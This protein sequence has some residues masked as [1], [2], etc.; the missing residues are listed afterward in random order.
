MF[1]T[2]IDILTNQTKY[3]IED[4][5]GNIRDLN[6][7][8][9][10][11]VTKNVLNDIDGKLFILNKN[12]EI[13]DNTFFKILIKTNNTGISDSNTILLPIQGTKMFI[14]WGDNSYGVYTQT[15]TPNNIINGFNISHTYETPGEYEIKISSRIT[16]ILFNNGGDRSKL[17]EI[18]QWGGAFWSTTLSAFWGC[19]KMKMPALDAPRNLIN[20]S[21][22]FNGCINFGR[23]EDFTNLNN[24]DVSNV[25]ILNNTFRTA[26]NFNQPL[27]N[28]NTTKVTN[29]D[30]TFR[31]T[32]FNQDISNW[33]VSNV[34]TSRLTFDGLGAFNQDLSNWNITS[35]CTN[36]SEMFRGCQNFNSD[37]SNW[38][39]S[40]VISFFG[41]FQNAR[42]FNQDLS[43]WNVSKCTNFSNMF[44]DARDFNNNGNPDINNWQIN[45]EQPVLMTAMFGTTNA[46]TATVFNQPIGNWNVSSVTNMADM[47]RLNTN[48]NQELNDWDVSNVVN[49]GNMFNGSTGFNKNIG[50]WNVGLGTTFTSFM[51]NKSALN[52]SEENLDNIYNGWVKYKLQPSRSISFGSIKRTTNS[53][54]SK[55]LLTRP[56][57]LLTISNIINNGDDLIRVTTTTP[58]S[59]ITGDMVFIENVIGTIEA[60]GLWSIT[61]VDDFTVDLENSIFVNEFITSGQL[62]T[63][64]GWTIIDGGL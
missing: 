27:S 15:N 13:N 40:N 59:R 18:R 39:V 16:R 1:I 48:F 35:K 49:F 2:A 41:T 31:D 14:D 56:N 64:Y 45:T 33:D 21:N 44:R 20:L 7:L 17:L 52:Y 22:M 34:T 58:H 26:R 47:F 4:K 29:L 9:L 3:L 36:I 55:S 42:I 32:T 63:G 54:N 43:N 23:A 51:A 28:W 24:W 38:D 25:T 19:D 62:R 37:I 6:G 61:Y 30:N 57:V 12:I 10:F 60:N 46:L 8:P 5:N 11:F 53:N 50:N